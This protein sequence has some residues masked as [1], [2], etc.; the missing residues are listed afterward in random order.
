M[1]VPPHR[2]S[3]T[4]YLSRE[5]SAKSAF[6]DCAICRETIPLHHK[7]LSCFHHFC[8]PCI[9]MWVKKKDNP[10]CP[11]CRKPICLSMFSYPYEDPVF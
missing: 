5:Q 10:C 1:Y 3:T 2:R 7:E 8:R 4:Y 11:L 6:G 9:N